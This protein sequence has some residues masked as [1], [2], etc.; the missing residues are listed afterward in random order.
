MEMRYLWLVNQ[1]SQ[2]YFKF[3]YHPGA[4]LMANYPFE[5]QV[6]LDNA[7]VRTTYT[8]TPHSLT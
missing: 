4:E 8:W 1:A 6:G 5:D 3:Y 7:H 2:K